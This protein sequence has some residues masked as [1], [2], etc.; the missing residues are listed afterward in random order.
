M[1]INQKLIRAAEFNP[2]EKSHKLTVLSMCQQIEKQQITL[3]LYQRD[4]SW[5]LHKRFIDKNNLIQKWDIIN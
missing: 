2:T 3:P 4:M 1:N 5:N